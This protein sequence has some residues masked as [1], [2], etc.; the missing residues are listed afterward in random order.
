MYLLSPNEY[1]RVRGYFDIYPIIYA[2]F[3]TIQHR[4]ICRFSPSL[5]RGRLGWGWVSYA[6]S[7]TET[8][9][10]PN[11]PLEREGTFPRNL[12][13]FQPHHRVLNSY[14]ES[15]KS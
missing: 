15:T 8:H 4:R 13:F 12:Y 2:K 1:V 14:I 5:S 6:V 11:P 7:A 10:H 3:V 9:P